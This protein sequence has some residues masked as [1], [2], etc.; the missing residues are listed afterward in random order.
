MNLALKGLL[1]SD[2]AAID[3]IDPDYYT[4]VVTAINAGIDMAMVPTRRHPFRLSDFYQCNEAGS[5]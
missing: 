2:W 3:Q 5:R 4:A 1:I